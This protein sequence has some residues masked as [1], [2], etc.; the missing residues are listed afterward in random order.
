VFVTRLLR[1]ANFVPGLAQRPTILS[2]AINVFGLDNLKPLALGLSAFS[3]DTELEGKNGEVDDGATNRRNLWEHALGCAITAARLASKNQ[4]IS[5]LVAFTAGFIHD[6]GK[7]LLYRSSREK[8]MAAQSVALEKNL[9]STEGEMLVFGIDHVMAAENWCRKSGLPVTLQNVLRLH[10]QRLGM[11]ESIDDESR[12]LIAIVQAADLTCE[13]QTIGKADAWG[14]LP[15]E[16]RAALD[17]CEE[18]RRALLPAVRQEMESA[19]HMFGF[20]RQERKPQLRRQGAERNEAFPLPKAGATSGRRLII[21]FPFRHESGRPNDANQ[22]VGKLAILVVEDHTS[23]C[24][25]LSRYLMRHGYHLR[26]ANNGK[27]ALEILSKDEIQLVLL[28]LMP[29][30][31]DGFEVLRQIHDGRHEKTPYI[32]VVSAGLSEKDRKTALELGANEYLPEPF[33]LLRLLER[34][35]T[36]EKYLF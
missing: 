25:L 36:V 30:R 1:L 5:P 14:V 10:H 3:L 31:V 18:D 32:I 13:A 33:H 17:F 8:L 4:S 9:P 26:T 19:R 7:V 29:P 23:L 22:S 28:D 24:D 35:R 15:G 20:P 21:P 12:R 16:L 2:D 6:V 27:G 11:L 34:I